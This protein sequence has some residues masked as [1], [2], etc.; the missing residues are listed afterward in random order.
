M[1]FRVFLARRGALP[2]ADASADST[3]FRG[4]RLRV[5]G[6]QVCRCDFALVWCTQSLH[7][8]NMSPSCLSAAHKASLDAELS[9]RRAQGCVCYMVTGSGLSGVTS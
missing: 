7:R 5:V 1:A 9:Y 4:L 6:L 2:A 8:A 3:D